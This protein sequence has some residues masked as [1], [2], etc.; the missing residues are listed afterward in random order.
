M[1]IMSL[2]GAILGLAVLLWAGLSTGVLKL[3]IN[4][5]GFVIVVGG[6]LAS[7]AINTNVKGFISGI[8]AF[9]YVIKKQNLPAVDESIQTIVEL[10]DT[11]HRE[12]GIMALQNVDPVFA[13]GFLKRAIT[14]AMTS[15]QSNETRYILEDEVRRMRLLRQEN[16]NFYRT[17]GVISPMFGLM[18]TLFGIIQTLSNLSDPSKIGLSMAVAITSALYGIA[19]SNMVFVPIANKLRVNAMEETM[20]L[21]LIVEGVIDIMSGKPPHLIDMHLKGYLQAGEL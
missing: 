2:G 16:S 1:D 10:S 9:V 4:L 20:I 5:H 19:L 6:T 21:Q 8:K 3:L 7:I 13:G 17:M 11:A 12:G 15:G 18:G 14:V